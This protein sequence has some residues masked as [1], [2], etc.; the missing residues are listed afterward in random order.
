MTLSPVAA[1][2]P[3]KVVAIE[4]CAAWTTRLIGVVTRQGAACALGAMAQE[5]TASKG[6]WPAGLTPAAWVKPQRYNSVK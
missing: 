4:V 2:A 1:T 5:E 3:G 6:M